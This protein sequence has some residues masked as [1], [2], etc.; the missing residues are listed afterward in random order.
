MMFMG[1][2]VILGEEF[3]GPHATAHW[4]LV[5][6]LNLPWL[7]TPIF[8]TLRLRKEHPFSVESSQVSN[9]VVNAEQMIHG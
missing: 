3:A 2:T 1:V 9:P 6:V 5:L 4:P 8:L 7:L